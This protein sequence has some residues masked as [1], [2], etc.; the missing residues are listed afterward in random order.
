VSA[1]FPFQEGREL[2]Q[3]GFVFD[4]F[5]SQATAQHQVVANPFA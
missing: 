2:F 1:A 5:E 4:Q 3:T